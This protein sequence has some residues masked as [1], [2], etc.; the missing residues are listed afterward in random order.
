MTWA[1][2][3]TAAFFVA[4]ECQQ[5]ED[6]EAAQDLRRKYRILGE[7]GMDMEN[8]DA[9][10]NSLDVYSWEEVLI[11]TAKEGPCWPTKY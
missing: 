3:L 5:A 6:R 7:L 11:M 4:Q 8:S 2:I 10:I 9:A 1:A